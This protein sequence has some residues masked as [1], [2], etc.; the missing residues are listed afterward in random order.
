MPE[1]VVINVSSTFQPLP[2]GFHAMGWFRAIGLVTPRFDGQS[3]G[4][5][6]VGP[7]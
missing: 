4:K 2:V 5:K 7:P 1:A 6:P 3:L